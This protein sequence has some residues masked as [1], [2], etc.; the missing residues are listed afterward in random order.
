ME[1]VQQARG[2]ARA[3]EIKQK[4]Y[5]GYDLGRN[6]TYGMGGYKGF[7]NKRGGYRTIPKYI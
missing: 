3:G 2:M 7:K 4:T 5:S 1:N 6:V